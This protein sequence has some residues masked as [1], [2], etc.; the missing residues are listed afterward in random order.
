LRDNESSGILEAQQLWSDNQRLLF[1]G[2]KLQDNESSCTLEAQQPRRGEQ[3]L[4]ARADS[5]HTR[6]KQ[7]SSA[8]A[9]VRYAA[10]SGNH[11]ENDSSLKD[12]EAT[13][14]TQGVAHGGGH[15]CIKSIDICS[16]APETKAT[17]KQRTESQAKSAKS[18]SLTKSASNRSPAKLA[19]SRVS[20]STGGRALS[21]S[22][23]AKTNTVRGEGSQVKE[24]AS[25]SE[26]EKYPYHRGFR[27]MCRGMRENVNI[28]KSVWNEAYLQG[29]NDRYI[30]EIACNM[31]HLT[32]GPDANYYGPG[33]SDDDADAIALC[34]RVEGWGSGDSNSSQQH[35]AYHSADE[36]SRSELGSRESSGSQQCSNYTSDDE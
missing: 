16:Q 4:L 19:G 21:E 10:Y 23:G 20:G 3:Q 28:S 35:S 27:G 17:S 34:H 13:L 5:S 2:D 1:E 24:Q 9:G 14:Q 33:H 6:N 8:A 26:E 32:L 22:L 18:G 7:Q 30:D 29:F 31:Q 25:D 15:G 11:F 36:Y 12:G